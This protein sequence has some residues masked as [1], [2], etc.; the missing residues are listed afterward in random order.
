[1]TTKTWKK[2]T[3]NGNP[4]SQLASHCA[5]LVNRHILVYGGTGVPF[6]LSSSNQIYTCNLD[7]LKWE[8]IIPKDESM[9]VQPVEQYGQA[10]AFDQ[11]NGCLYVVGGTTGYL[12]TID[13]HKFDLH[14]RKWTQL[15][16]QAPGAFPTF[17]EPRYRHEVV[18]HQ[19]KLYI[20]GG[21]TADACFGFSEVI[22]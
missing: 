16:K 14:T 2:L 9:D 1:M 21:G 4:P 18:L 20:F 7:T 15:Y 5:V 19:Q 12:Y 3:T 17:P 8:L 22:L 6:G 13:V 10:I 11:D